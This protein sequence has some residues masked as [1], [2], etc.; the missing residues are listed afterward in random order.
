ME[1]SQ[2]PVVGSMQYVQL[3]KQKNGLLK[4]KIKKAQ[5]KRKRKREE[6]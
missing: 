4:N 1:K 5:S 6:P 3:T 2:K